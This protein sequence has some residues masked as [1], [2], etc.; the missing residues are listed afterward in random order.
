MTTIETQYAMSC[1]D[2]ALEAT[3]TRLTEDPTYFVYRVAQQ[4]LLAMQTDLRMTGGAN[5]DRQR[6]LTIGWLAVRELD[7]SD[8]EYEKALVA[9]A[10]A[11][12]QL[13]ASSDVA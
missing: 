12:Q 8:P 6:T 2:S 11:Y 1:I 9:A 3:G 4:E 10:H 5:A 13:V 7:G